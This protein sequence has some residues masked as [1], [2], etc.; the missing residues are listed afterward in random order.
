MRKLLRNIHLWLSVPLG[1]VIAVVCFSG[2]ML[3]FEQEIVSVT[4][5]SLL[6]VD[7]APG[8]PL[9]LGELMARAGQSLPHGAKA[10]GITVSQD[11]RRAY[12]VNLSKPRGAAIII[13]QYTGRVRGIYER[14]AFFRVMFGL[15]RWLLDSPRSRGSMSWGKA[16]VGVS[17]IM[18]VLALVSGAAAWWPRRG[19]SLSRALTVT[20]RHGRH[21]LWHSL[22]CAG[23][24]YAVVLLLA[25]SLTGLTWSFGWYNAA[26]Y[27]LF[28]VENTGRGGHGPAKA[29]Q[30]GSAPHSPVRKHGNP[31]AHGPKVQKAA[32]D[33]AQAYPENPHAG[34]GDDHGIFHVPCGAHPVC[35]NEGGD[36]DQRLDNGDK[37]D[38]LQTHP[39][40]FRFHAAQH[41]D[42]PCGGKY[43]QTAENEHQLRKP[44][45]FFHIVNGLVLPPG[46]DALSYHGHQPD[47]HPPGG[48]AV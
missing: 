17:V 15:H 30:K 6:F 20:A 29:E 16:V 33:D 24:M 42:G 45:E 26:F 41:R 1:L 18:F 11:P 32:E 36:P 12:R 14:P 34:A 39:G 44:G 4:H 46:P 2:A 35:G 48:D 25:M 7:D 28:G 40:A 37:G 5:R 23:G 19:Q 27:K 10:T 8:R 21:R 47:A 38:H 43:R 3:V 13:D 31:D 9:P 22:H